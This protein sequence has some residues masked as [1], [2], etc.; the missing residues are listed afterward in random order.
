MRIEAG[1]PAAFT[2]RQWLAAAAA[3]AAGLARGAAAPEPKWRPG[4]YVFTGHG[5]IGD[6]HLA[7]PF[8][9]VQ[10]CYAWSGLEPERG[11]YDFAAV[12]A[13]LDRLGRVDRRLVLQLQ[14][15][16]FGKDARYAPAYIEG[17][18]FGG[19]VYRASSGS[20]NPVIWNAAVGDRM[21]ALLAALGRAF[22]REE[23]LE[24]VVLPETAPSAG[25]AKTPQAGVDPYTPDGYASALERLMLALRR[26]FPGT[27]V[28]QYTNFPGDLLERLTAFMKEAG[29]GLGGPDVYPRPDAV[30]DP[31][32]GVY[33]FYPG[34]AGH[35]PLG[36]A[37]QSPNYSVAAKK[38]TAMFDRGRDRAEARIEP[39][40]ETPIPVR[41]HLKLARETLKLNYLF[42]SASP[43]ECLANVKRMLAEPDLAGDPAGGLVT[44]LPARAFGRPS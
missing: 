42:W 6:E 25:L 31:V 33:R 3:G 41:E 9:G 18:A 35:V 11:R 2:R 1:G 12:R 23:A 19:G 22:D 39:G 14:Y 16:A 36:A 28:I 26:S 44:A 21:E 38:R 30:S 40:D 4:H 24:A 20:L 10:R 37:V 27:V 13:D 43:R 15:K 34:L 8:R 29:V 7:G 5:A 32:R 17:A